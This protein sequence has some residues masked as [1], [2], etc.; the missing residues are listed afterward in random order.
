MQASQHID[1]IPHRKTRFQ[2]VLMCVV[3]LLL[4]IQLMGTAFHKHEYTDTKS[5]CAT[6]SFIHHLPSGLPDVAVALLPVMMPLVYRIL[7]AGS[8]H[9]LVQPS[10]LIPRSQAPPRRA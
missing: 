4:S 8:Y 3:L 9:F 1:N 5:D 6:C 2:R 10:Y 7:G